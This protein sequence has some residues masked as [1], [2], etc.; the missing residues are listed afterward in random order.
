MEE[1]KL[2]RR[3]LD[4][5]KRFHESECHRY[6]SQLHMQSQNTDNNVEIESALK[7]MKSMQEQLDAAKSQIAMLQS[8]AGSADLNE[9]SGAALVESKKPATTARRMVG[10][11][12]AQRV[13]PRGD[14]L[15]TYVEQSDMYERK[16]EMMT[17][18]RREM[19]AKNLEENKER[20]ELNQKL[21]Q[22]EKETAS[23]K[24]KVTKLTLEKERLARRLA[25]QEDQENIPR[26]VP[27]L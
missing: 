10:S 3:K 9:L 14:N 11:S 1:E 13:N 20:M 23:Y 7:E 22:C 21:L 12:N 18:E 26:A 15:S 27:L 24:S 17:R 6:K 25:K 8:R 5:E 4:R 2:K 16:I 19:I